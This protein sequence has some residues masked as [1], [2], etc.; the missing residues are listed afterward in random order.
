MAKKG[1][2]ASATK[3][4]QRQAVGMPLEFENLIGATIAAIVIKRPRRRKTSKPGTQR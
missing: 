2:P 3:D 1:Q 4:D